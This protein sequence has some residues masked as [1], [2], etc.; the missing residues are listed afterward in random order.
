MRV[1]GEKD[2]MKKEISFHSQLHLFS[3]SFLTTTATPHFSLNNLITPSRMLRQLLHVS[4]FVPPRIYTQSRRRDDYVPREMRKRKVKGFT[5]NGWF[6][7]HLLDYRCYRLQRY[8]LN[9]SAMQTLNDNTMGKWKV[10]IRY[11]YIGFGFSLMKAIT[12][13]G[14]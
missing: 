8:F 13:K 5:E 2:K 14:Y 7:N 11:R 10:H 12:R 1:Y 4:T 3:H 6:L 9:E